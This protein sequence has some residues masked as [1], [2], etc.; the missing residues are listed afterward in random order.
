MQV[1]LSRSSS[2]PLRRGFLR[3]L[4]RL[5]QLTI[6]G[7][8]EYGDLYDPIEWMPDLSGLPRLRALDISGRWSTAILA[9]ILA[10]RPDLGPTLGPVDLDRATRVLDAVRA[11]GWHAAP[12]H[13]GPWVLPEELVSGV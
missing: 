2:R 10:A 4:P 1:S 12:F 6:C 9:E 5:E 3:A 13:L 11:L 8:L 7:G